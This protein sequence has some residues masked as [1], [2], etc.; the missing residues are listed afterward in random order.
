M[1]E[2][3]ADAATIRSAA[4]PSRARPLVLALLALALLGLV[5][6][7]ERIVLVEDSGELRPDHPH[8]VRLEARH[9]NVE[10]RGAV[11]LDVL[12]GAPG[13]GLEV[14]LLRAGGGLVAGH[15]GR[16]VLLGGRVGLLRFAHVFDAR[17]R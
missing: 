10:G 15:P 7:G 4:A 13:Q 12:V 11:G 8:V 1:T 2:I 6:P 9:G 14:A 3:T 16:R 5:A 17:P